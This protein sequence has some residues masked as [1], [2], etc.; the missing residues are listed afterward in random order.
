MRIVT[1]NN[2][3]F[4]IDVHSVEENN[5]SIYFMDENDNILLIVNKDNFLYAKE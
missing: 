3:F 4:D 2:G 1:V 5:N